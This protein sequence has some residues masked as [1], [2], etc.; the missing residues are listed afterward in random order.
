M[1]RKVWIR[2][3]AGMMFVSLAGGLVGATIPSG[4]ASAACGTFLGLPRW[5]SG[6]EKNNCN[7]LKSPSEL[8]GGLQT[9]IWVIALNVIE[10]ML[11]IVGYLALFFIIYGGFQ[12]IVSSGSPDRMARAQKT[13]LNAAIGLIIAISA[14]AAKDLIWRIVLGNNN[15]EY[16][17]PMQDNAAA[18]IVAALNLVYFVAAAAAV[19]VIV[20][21]GITYATSA[22]DPGKTAK[23]KNTILYSAVG[24]AI[25]ICAFAIT[26]FIAGTFGA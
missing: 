10:I 7:D 9:Y 26:R 11:R 13:V 6:L 15:P 8:Q 1:M 17:I 24:I 2:L 3:V 5:S 14:I 21:A 19:I 12:L 16:G 22:G 20:V 23:A 25:V 4:Q 18:V